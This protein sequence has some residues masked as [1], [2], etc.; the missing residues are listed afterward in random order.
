[1]GFIAALLLHRGRLSGFDL[2]EKNQSW[3]DYIFQSKIGLVTSPIVD[4]RYRESIF[5]GVFE[6]LN[7]YL[8]M[9]FITPYVQDK[10]GS[11][12]PN[13]SIG[14]FIIIMLIL[15]CYRLI[16]IRAYYHFA[17]SIGIEI[18]LITFIGLV[19]WLTILRPQSADNIHLNVVIFFLPFMQFLV[20]IVFIDKSKIEKFGLYRTST[21]KF[22]LY[23]SVLAFLILL[24]HLI[25]VDSIN[26]NF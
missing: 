12:I 20:A 2:A 6:N 15:I 16:R 24:S 9:P 13:F 10:L 14:A 23:F 22:F 5:I 17:T 3:S 21:I 25:L 7:N 26:S 8:N 18:L 4:P 1:L 11:F 19:S